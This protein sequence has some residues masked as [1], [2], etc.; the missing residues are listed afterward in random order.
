MY[1]F[2][3]HV[4]WYHNLGPQATAKI[5]LSTPEPTNSWAIINDFY[6]EVEKEYEKLINSNMIGDCLVYRG[7]KV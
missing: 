7:K 5:A 6:K 3:N 2:F 4:F 1:P